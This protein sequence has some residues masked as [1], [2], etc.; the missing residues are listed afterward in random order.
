MSN[1]LTLAAVIVAIY[2]LAVVIAKIAFSISAT[3]NSKKSR[4]FVRLGAES[5]KSVASMFFQ[6]VAYGVAFIVACNAVYRGFSDGAKLPVL[7]L[8]PPEHAV[9]LLFVLTLLLCLV[10]LLAHLAHL[11][12]AFLVAI[13]GDDVD[14]LGYPK[15]PNS[16]VIE[17]W[18]NEQR[19]YL[20][21]SKKKAIWLLFPSLT[22]FLLL[23][24]LAAT[25]AVAKVT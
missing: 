14:K 21:I 4:A 16:E 7:G 10:L 9:W 5:P 20:H 11:G 18:I 6:N 25:L 17:I 22:I 15:N 1:F 2:A 23:T 13:F 12:S 19:N 24:V 8:I 3:A